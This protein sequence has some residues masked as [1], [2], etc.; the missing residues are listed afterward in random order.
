DIDSSDNY[1]TDKIMSPDGTMNTIEYPAEK[2][3]HLK[4]K[5]G[6]IYKIL[7]KSDIKSNGTRDTTKAY[8]SKD[9]EEL[10]PK[11]NVNLYKEIRDSLFNIN[12][13]CMKLSLVSSED[14]GLVDKI[15]SARKDFLVNI[16]GDMGFYNETY[17]TLSKKSSAYRSMINN[18]KAKLYNMG[19][20]NTLRASL[21]SCNARLDSLNKERDKYLKLLADSEATI[22]IIDPDNEI[23]NLYNSIVDELS[24]VRK[25]LMRFNSQCHSLYERL[26]LDPQIVDIQSEYES[27]SGRVIKVKSDIEN[28]KSRLA[29][30]TVQRDSVVKSIDST[31][32][33]RESL[34][35]V[36]ISDDIETVIDDLKTKIDM[37]GAYLKSMEQDPNITKSELETADIILASIK[38]AIDNMRDKYSD[39]DLNYLESITSN[40]SVQEWIELQ[41]KE[42]SEAEKSIHEL[43]DRKS[44]LMIKTSELHR[45][46]EIKNSV[47]S[48]RPEGCN[49]DTCPFLLEAI[50]LSNNKIDSEYE[51]SAIEYDVVKNYITNDSLSLAHMKYQLEMVIDFNN[52][53]LKIIELNKPLLSKLPRIMHKLENAHSIAYAIAS[54]N[55]FDEFSSIKDMIKDMDLVEDY[56]R[57]STELTTLES[58]YIVYKNNK[59]ME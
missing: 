50:E 9:G 43:E 38:V 39:Y 45:Q 7:I 30:A 19:D 18:I 8:I 23:Q 42:I 6:S 10:N 41:R 3:I 29:Q 27:V 47:L 46:I 54:H 49:I 11:G 24:D 16:M 20:E 21:V 15:P 56:N 14:R 33:K 4:D 26:E 52:S 40:H 2:E 17:K 5:A 53:V 55:G 35:S 58:E 51:E 59:I 22:R 12:S 25:D 57:C 36:D 44:E 31:R 1:R 34:I 13:T 37:Y 32:V 48:K 28:S